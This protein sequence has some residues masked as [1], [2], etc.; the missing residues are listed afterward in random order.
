MRRAT[1]AEE[2]HVPV[3]GRDVP[4]TSKVEGRN[5]CGCGKVGL[6]LVRRAGLLGYTPEQIDIG[7]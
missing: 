1:L 4:M 6:S 5:T 7:T 2:S 3:K